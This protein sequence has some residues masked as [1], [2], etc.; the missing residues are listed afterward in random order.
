MYSNKLTVRFDASGQIYNSI[1]TDPN[2][3]LDVSLNESSSET[4][5]D[6]RN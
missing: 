4:Q 2:V 1:A 3:N 6:N 5:T